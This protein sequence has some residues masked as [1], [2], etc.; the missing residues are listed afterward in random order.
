MM[1][2]DEE[3]KKLINTQNQNQINK[4]INTSRVTTR[5]QFRNMNPNA[6]LSVSQPNI[7]IPPPQ[8][9]P[10][11]NQYP[12]QQ[13]SQ[14]NINIPQNQ[15]INQPNININNDNRGFVDMRNVQVPNI[16]EI[17][18]QQ[19][20]QGFRYISDEYRE[21]LRKEPE[22]KKKSIKDKIF[23]ALKRRRTKKK[24]IS[25]VQTVINA[26]IKK[27]TSDKN[28]IATIMLDKRLEPK[29]EVIRITQLVMSTKVINNRIVLSDRISEKPLFTYYST[30]ISNMKAI[31]NDVLYLWYIFYKDVMGDINDE[32][33][34]DSFEEIMLEHTKLE[35][36]YVVSAPMLIS[37]E[38]KK[39]YY[40]DFSGE[41][42]ALNLKDINAEIREQILEFKANTDEFEY[43]KTKYLVS[44][45]RESCVIC[46]EELKVKAPVLYSDMQIIS[47]ENDKMELIEK[48]IPIKRK[49]RFLACRLKGE[50][51]C[52]CYMIFPDKINIAALYKI[53]LDNNYLFEYLEKYM[54]GDMTFQYPRNVCYW[55]TLD[56][57]V[58]FMWVFALTSRTIDENY[59]SSLLDHLSIYENNKSAFQMWGTV[60]LEYQRLLY[61]YYN[62]FN[63]RIKFDRLLKL[64]TKFQANVEARAALM[65]DVTYDQVIEFFDFF[66][67]MAAY[68]NNQFTP[69]T[70][71]IAQHVINAL[72]KLDEGSLTDIAQI[73]ETGILIY[74]VSDTPEDSRYIFPAFPFI[75]SPGAFL[76]NMIDDTLDKYDNDYLSELIG[77][78]EDNKKRVEENN[79]KLF[80][81]LKK[82]FGDSLNDNIEEVVKNNVA[83]IFK[84]QSKDT[85]DKATTS[86]INSVMKDRE[87]KEEIG[88]AII[89]AGLAGTS[90]G[91]IS[92]EKN[93]RFGKIIEGIKDEMKLE[94]EKKIA[95]QNLEENNIKI[96]MK[97]LNNKLN[98][99]SNN[100]RNIN[101]IKKALD[102]STIDIN[103]TKQIGLKK[104]RR[105]DNLTVTTQTVVGE[106]DLVN[107]EDLEG[108]LTELEN[109]NDINNNGDGKGLYEDNDRI[110]VNGEQIPLRVIDYIKTCCLI[111][112][113]NAG[114]KYN[115]KLPQLVDKRDY[116]ISQLQK[117]YG[118]V[119]KDAILNSDDYKFKDEVN[120]LHQNPK[121]NPIYPYPVDE[122][123]RKA[124]EIGKRNIKFPN[125]DFG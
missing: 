74:M 23:L 98:N 64:L 78:Y 112:A 26:A 45:T 53:K 125:E 93:K 104:R 37:G 88:D 55:D 116:S 94:E 102:D 24:E 21:A 30:F 90:I 99:I 77:R 35:S 41:F 63:T 46:S 16:N 105:R 28:A 91:D 61:D 114:K 109:A 67:Q 95:Q 13:Q 10:P 82:T 59:K 117:M 34:Q 6:N 83:T 72:A 12:Q 14:F 89:K 18:Q 71:V 50:R 7:N 107:E 2:D 121:Y 27:K 100:K 5:S 62:S 81:N 84:N 36:V 106:Q 9:P 119:G 123:F 31:T 20:Q 52:P 87:M 17:Q 58:D 122:K 86:A 120:K 65:K 22:K 11:Q 76:G 29:D 75:L 3:N 47:T 68:I 54:S 79:D 108:A 48:I 60:Q 49:P 103:T 110:S 111:A 43:N 51:F 38:I 19:Q 118:L 33:E 70:Q 101:K 57:F 1:S 73:R 32:Y 40:Q 80:S 44:G 4:N 25:D 97:N 85:V 42:L 96:Q 56:S 113:S 66:G 8:G 15:N 115:G 92:F 39:G 69:R 124:L